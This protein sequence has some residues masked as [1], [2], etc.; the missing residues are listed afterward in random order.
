MPREPAAN[1]T[2][3]LYEDPDYRAR[4]VAN[5]RD[6]AQAIADREPLAAL[7]H[8]SLHYA[9]LRRR[10]RN[11]DDGANDAIKEQ[12][13]SARCGPLP[14]KANGSSSSVGRLTA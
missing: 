3:A 2:M 9:W 7:S 10:V 6:T 12:T 14:R 11:G 8:I 13:C 4:T 5:W 1:N